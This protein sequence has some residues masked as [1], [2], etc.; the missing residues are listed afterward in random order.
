[1]GASASTLMPKPA[2]A[3]AEGEAEKP[4]AAAAFHKRRNTDALSRIDPV[5][6]G[7]PVFRPEGEALRPEDIEL[8]NGLNCHTA[9]YVV[10]ETGSAAVCFVSE[11]FERRTGV[12]A[13][14]A[15]GKSALA[16]LRELV[17]LSSADEDAI[18]AAFQSTED[19][20]V[21]VI[22]K[23]V[24]QDEASEICVQWFIS[25]MRVI[26]SGPS[27]P[28]FR[29]CAPQRS[30]DAQSCREEPSRS[31]AYRLRNANNCKK[32]G[33]GSQDWMLFTPYKVLCDTDKMLVDMLQERCE[34][35]CITDPVMHDN[36]IVFV[37]DGF[38]D[39]TGYNRYEI[40]GINCRFL[41]GHDT[42]PEDV[43]VIRNAINERKHARVCLLNYRKDGTTFIN[44]FNISPLRD[45]NGR[46][47]YFI[48]VQMEVEDAEI[49]P[50]PNTRQSMAEMM[51]ECER[52]DM[53][54]SFE[55][56]AN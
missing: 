31:L 2:S 27:A 4:P 44:Q 25:P 51:V 55:Q 37:S 7:S 46:L 11:A 47:A 23:P 14:R 32:M 22:G 24:G 50:F 26:T 13:S 9:A 56:L 28:R 54:R 15:Q 38:I 49:L 8:M 6:K 41:Q 45:A 36:P 16:L 52:E 53:A 18:T 48:G 12:P 39:M 10:V 43:A 5:A 35:F 42:S 1:M 33:T 34:M 19:S 3:A 21:P 20:L 17:H 29:L 40:N 30:P